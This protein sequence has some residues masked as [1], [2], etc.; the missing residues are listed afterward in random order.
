M[1]VTRDSQLTCRCAFH[2]L[3]KRAAHALLGGQQLAFF[4]VQCLVSGAGLM[5]RSVLLLLQ[6]PDAL[7]SSLKLRLRPVEMKML[8]YIRKRL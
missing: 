7:F 1:V 5:H 4:E 6:L 3:S 2:V 8:C